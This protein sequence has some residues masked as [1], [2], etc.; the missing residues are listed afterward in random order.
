MG[1]CWQSTELNAAN[2]QRKA[3]N[4]L[5]EVLRTF[6]KDYLK[7]LNRSVIPDIDFQAFQKSA[8]TVS[9]LYLWTFQQ[10]ALPISHLLAKYKEMFGGSRL[11]HSTVSLWFSLLAICLF[12][13]PQIHSL[14]RVF[15]PLVIFVPFKLPLAFFS[16]QKRNNADKMILRYIYTQVSDC[17]LSHSCCIEYFWVSITSPDRRSKSDWGSG[18]HHLPGRGSCRLGREARSNRPPPDPA[19]PAASQTLTEGKKQQH[20]KWVI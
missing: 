3:L 14:T 6:P 10:M 4:V 7:K 17:Q 2:I 8:N 11:L 18:R 20:S 13:C 16:C 15:Q 19:G 12:V 9:A 5:Q 1:S